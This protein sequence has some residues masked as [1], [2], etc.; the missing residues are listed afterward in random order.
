MMHEA[1]QLR[2]NLV[3][4]TSSVFPSLHLSK[5]ENNSSFPLLLWSQFPLQGEAR[6]LLSLLL[7]CLSNLLFSWPLSFLSGLASGQQQVFQALASFCTS[8]PVNLSLFSICAKS[9][10]QRTTNLRCVSFYHTCLKTVLKC[11]LRQNFIKLSIKLVIKTN[12][13]GRFY[14]NLKFLAHCTF[15]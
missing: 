6:C 3:R 14:R 8:P 1:L 13:T 7:P 12:P 5:C 15:L 10:S 2:L 9:R 4:D 11:P